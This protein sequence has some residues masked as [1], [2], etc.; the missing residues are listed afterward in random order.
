MRIMKLLSA[1]FSISLLAAAC[2]QDR[3]RQAAIIDPH[4]D[5]VAFSGLSPELG[6]YVAKENFDLRR[7]GHLLEQSDDFYEFESL[8]NDDGGIN[9]LDFNYDGYADYISVEE[10]E[11]R[12]PYER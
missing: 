3:T 7:V 1:I 2:N 5:P 12:G 11:D 9:N 10:F 6:G 8:L 4:L